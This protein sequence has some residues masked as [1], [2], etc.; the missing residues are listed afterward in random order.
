[1]KYLEEV[2]ERLNKAT[3]GPWSTKLT[4]DGGGL[5]IAGD[6]AFNGFSIQFK[7]PDNAVFIANS[8][9]DIEKLIEIVEIQLAALNKIET[10]CLKHGNR[11]LLIAQDA[12]V[13]VNKVAEDEK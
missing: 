11:D 8:R 2:K 5:V 10:E 13:R 12:F 4:S 6:A 3:T 1:M 7:E 9:R